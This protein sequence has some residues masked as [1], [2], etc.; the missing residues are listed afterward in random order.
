MSFSS[1]TA[2]VSSDYLKAQASAPAPTAVVSGSV[3]TTTASLNVRK[4]GGSS[5]AVLKVVAKGVREVRRDRPEMG[6]VL[7]THYQ[8]ILEELEPDVVHILMDGR[9]VESGGADL[10]HRLE[11]EG[12]EAWQRR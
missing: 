5:H 10:A 12:Y 4:G 2:Y 1:G 7:I 8:R 6:V 3:R 9:I 11:A